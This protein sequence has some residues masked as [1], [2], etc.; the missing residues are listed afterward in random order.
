MGLKVETSMLAFKGR[1]LVDYNWNHGNEY[2]VT[3]LDTKGNRERVRVPAYM[4][5]MFEQYFAVTMGVETMAA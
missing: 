4:K 1:T 3:L 5:D 2:T